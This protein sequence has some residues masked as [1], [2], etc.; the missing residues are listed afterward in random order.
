[1]EKLLYPCDSV[2]AIITGPSNSG[3]TY[4]LTNLILNIIDDFQKIYIYSPSLHQDLYQKIIRCMNAFF[5]TQHVIQNII[6]EGYS[7]DDIDS[8]IEI[9]VNDPD[10][11][12][13]EKEIETYDSVEELKLP[14]NMM[15]E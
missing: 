2:R 15:G 12:S 6:N 10:F 8:V 3:K 9:I 14:K 11:E 7:I 5:T 1:M 4:F 13:S